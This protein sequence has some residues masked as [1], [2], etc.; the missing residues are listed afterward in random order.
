MAK[1]KATPRVSDDPS[2]PAMTFA[3]RFSNYESA[4]GRVKFKVRIDGH[5]V[6]LTQPQLCAL[7][8]RLKQQIS[9]Y[10]AAA[11][12]DGALRERRDVK[13]FVT[14]NSFGSRLPVQHYSLQAM[15]VLSDRLPSKYG[16]HFLTWA[17]AKL[18][19]W[20]K[21]GGSEV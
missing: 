16:P 5:T 15:Q 13:I 6:W 7:L 3:Y 4:D 2:A 19:L 9:A 1:K 14:P 20:A 8:Q 17:Q 21:T 11:I 18:A 10:A 12:R